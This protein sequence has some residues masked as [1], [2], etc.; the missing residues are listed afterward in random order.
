MT[1]RL[2]L[3]LALLLPGAGWSASGDRLVDDLRILSADDMAGRRAGTPGSARARAYLRGR[4]KE[5]GF[6]PAEQ[7]FEAR[8]A[9]GE[10]VHGVNLTALMP[11]TGKSDRLIVLSAHYDH[12]GVRDGKIYNGADDNASG[13]AAVLAIAERLKADPPQHGVLIALFD[14]EESGSLGAEAFLKAPP[15]AAGRIALNIN[16]DMVG[17]GDKGELY[18]AGATHY[19]F[20]RPRLERLAAGVPVTLKLG[21]DGPP[22]PE[23]DDWTAQSDHR[24]FHQAGIPFA[25]FGVEDHP[26]Y[27][28]PTDDFAKVPQPFFRDAAR[29]VE[30][31]VRLF[32]AELEAIAGEAAAA[33]R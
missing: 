22:W 2:L 14:A 21:H 25:Y 9:K 30:A 24:V 17:R 20:L 27:H 7:P 11:G 19:P 32:D 3:A 16:L 12:L 1:A 31:A 13:V 15:V 6:P 10:A 28:Q 33:R 5:I 8:S 23:K 18:V 4:L 29:T 26:D